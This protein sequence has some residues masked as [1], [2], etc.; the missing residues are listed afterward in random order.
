MTYSVQVACFLS[1]RGCFHFVASCHFLAV[2]K[3]EN[4]LLKKVIS[5][6]A[7]VSPVQGISP[8]VRDMYTWDSWRGHKVHLQ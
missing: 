6:K 1:K 8:E 7:L 5:V 4:M 2:R 3:E